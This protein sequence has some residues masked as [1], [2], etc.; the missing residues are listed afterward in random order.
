MLPKEVT[1]HIEELKRKH[2]NIEFIVLYGSYALGQQ[3]R[4]SDVDIGVKIKGK[5]IAHL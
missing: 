1:P 2:T 3:K 5:Q 4:W